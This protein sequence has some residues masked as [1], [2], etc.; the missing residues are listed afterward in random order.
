MENTMTLARSGVKCRERFVK[1][2]KAAPRSKRKELYKEEEEEE[3]EE[4]SFWRLRLLREVCS[5]SQE[6]KSLSET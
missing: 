2:V 3:V 5:S 1:K 6:E 4:E